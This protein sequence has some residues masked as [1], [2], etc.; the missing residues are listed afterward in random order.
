VVDFYC[1]KLRLAIEIDGSSHI[2]KSVYDEERDK[3]LIQ[4][5]IKTIRFTNNDVIKDI[6][7]VKNKIFSLVKGRSGIAERD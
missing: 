4:I 2:K 6:N 7:T 3:F 5:G 1:S